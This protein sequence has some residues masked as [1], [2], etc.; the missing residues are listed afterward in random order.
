MGQG[1]ESIRSEAGVRGR[2]TRAQSIDTP[3]ALIGAAHF[4]ISA[5]MNV[6]RYS[7][8][9][10]SGATTVTPTLSSRSRT[11]GESSASLV[12][13]ASRRTT[14]PGVPLGN[15]RAIQALQSRPGRPCS[16]AVG[17]FASTGGRVGPSVAIAFTAPAS[18]WGNAVEI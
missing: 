3:L 14:R 5:G 2:L 10:R 11:A 1:G 7:R 12:A 6:A 8:L 13:L 15:T 9:R 18:I 4:A 16:C 17:T